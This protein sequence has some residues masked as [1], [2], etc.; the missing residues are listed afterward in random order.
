MEKELQQRGIDKS[1]DEF[2]RKRGKKCLKKT[3]KKGEWEYDPKEPK[4]CYCGR[5]S[6]GEMVMCDNTFCER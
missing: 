3:F 2:R 4:Y 5:P 6:F 1:E